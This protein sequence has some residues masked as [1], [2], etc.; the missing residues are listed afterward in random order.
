VTNSS[1]SVMQLPSGEVKNT[2]V[3]AISA[4]QPMRPKVAPATML[5][6]SSCL[7]LGEP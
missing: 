2:T 6:N 3:T 5:F 4:G 1:L 7:P